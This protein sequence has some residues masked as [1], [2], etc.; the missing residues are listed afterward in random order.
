MAGLIP[1][2]RRIAEIGV[3][4]GATARQLRERMDMDATYFAIDPYPVGKLGI[5]F[6]KLIAKKT[7]GQAK[8][9]SVIWIRD[10]GA[11]AAKAG[12]ITC[13]PIDF[14]FIDGDHSL[15]GLKGDWEAWSGQVSIN[16]IVCL[17]D[18]C[19]SADR[20]LSDWGSK[21]FTEDVILKD[22]RFELIRQ[23]D[24]LTVLK[25]IRK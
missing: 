16:G 23:V 3:F 25:R 9:G 14:L 4:E 20:D 24:T 17:H 15:K 21:E 1:G 12:L 18:S 6:Q 19:S 2:R 11:N 10:T 5:N 22:A 8:N 7:V 13:A